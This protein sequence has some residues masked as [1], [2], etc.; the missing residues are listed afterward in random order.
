MPELE[1]FCLIPRHLRDLAAKPS[2]EA[3]ENR[4]IFAV[5]PGFPETEVTNTTN[6]GSDNQTKKLGHY[7]LYQDAGI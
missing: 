2:L 1:R 5:K 4:S 7:Q 6:D 3:H